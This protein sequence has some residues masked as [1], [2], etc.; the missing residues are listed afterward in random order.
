MRLRHWLIIGALA[1]VAFFA[2]VLTGLDDFDLAE[3]ESRE[4]AFQSDGHTL[5]G[6]LLRP[7]GVADPPIAVIVHGD[8]PQDRFS[9]G[10]YLPLFHV[11][12]DAGI[13]VFTWD[14]PGIGESE[15][16]WLDQS[17]PDRSAEA[18]TALQIIRDRDDVSS[19][20]VGFLGFSQ[21]GWVIP[22]ATHEVTP[23]FAVLIGPAVNWQEQGS[24]F[25][26]K[27]LE[28]EGAT[29]D[30][31]DA[32]IAANTERDA[33]IFAKDYVPGAED[34]RGMTPDRFAFVA[35]NHQADAT[36]DI[37]AMTGPVLA[38]WGADDLNVDAQTD[39]ARYRTLLPDPNMQSSLVIPDATHGLLRARFFNYQ[40]ADQWPAY[41]QALFLVA[42]RR[43]FAPDALDDIAK[44]IHVQVK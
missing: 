18:I 10:G 13:G 20:R 19:S 8:G 2:A 22:A 28:A 34:L 27:R 42:G 12:L 40:L 4:I 26:R 30:E 6:T 1:V 23:A 15:G 44:W 7:T 17:M 41:S 37:A 5:R 9:D 25:T 35:R 38:V 32:T 43:A 16:N 29:A 21:A 39:A 24:Y 11:L 33:R 3:F 31:I 14:K 36:D